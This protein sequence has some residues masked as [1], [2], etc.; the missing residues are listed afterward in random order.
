[1]SPF[2][3]SIRGWRGWSVDNSDRRAAPRRGCND[4]AWIQLD[5]GLLQQC[6]LLD[7]SRTGV[8]LTIANS[9]RIPDRFTLI[10]S[11][12]SRGLPARVKWRRHAQI[13]AEYSVK[14]TAQ[15]NA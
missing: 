5:G 2:A 7:I 10:L 9:H 3:L 13:G 11:K 14:R 15:A 4:D 12:N 8:R 6:R 1:M